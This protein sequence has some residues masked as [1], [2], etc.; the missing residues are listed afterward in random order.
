MINTQAL[1]NIAKQKL[2]RLEIIAWAM[3]CAT[4]DVDF[5]HGCLCIATDTGRL[6][7]IELVHKYDKL[8][9]GMARLIAGFVNLAQDVLDCRPAG[10]KYQRCTREPGCGGCRSEGLDCL[11]EVLAICETCNGVEGSLLPVCPGI[12]LTPAQHD[13]NYLDYQN[14]TGPFEGLR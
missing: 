6:S 1:R 2:S 12:L 7:T 10:H 9:G 11:Y 14:G 3:N 13:K 4:S 8:A 5:L